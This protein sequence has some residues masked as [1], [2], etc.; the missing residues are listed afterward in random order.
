MKLL[1]II[2]AVALFG[3]QIEKDQDKWDRYM[4]ELKCPIILIG[5]TDKT[6]EYPS[7]VVMGSEG[8][9]RTMNS[10][11]FYAT[12]AMPKA[13]ANSRDIGDTIKPCSTLWI[14]TLKP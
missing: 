6:V 2:L 12:V 9:V 10:N 11:D 7:I 13:I 3:C 8:R 14:E 4:S 5:K 1:I